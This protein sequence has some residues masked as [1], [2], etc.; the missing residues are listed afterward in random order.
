MS[1]TWLPGRFPSCA[2]NTLLTCS[3]LVFAG[4][5]SA[6]DFERYRPNPPTPPAYTPKLP[7][8][9][10]GPV[11][12]SPKILIKELKGFIVVDHKDK[13][14]ETPAE[15]HGI[16]ID[17]SSDLTL[18]RG[19]GVQSILSGYLGQEISIRK[20]NQM[21]RDIVLYY[22]K[23]GQPVVDVS[24]PPQDATDGVV[25]IVITEARIG[26]VIVK[27]GCYFDPKILAEQS[28]LR[29]GSRI[30]ERCL[31]EELIWYNQNPFR[32]VDLDLREGQH[33]GT[34]DVI[35]SLK[36]QLPL[37]VYA[38]YEDTGTR[39]T[40]RERLNYGFNCGNGLRRG[41]LMSYQ[42]TTND[43]YDNWD[44]ER[45]AVHSAS[46]SI[47]LE[48]RDELL[49]YGSFAEIEFPGRRFGLPSDFVSQGLS[50]QASVRYTR[51]QG[52]S[53]Y[54][55]D[56]RCS[57]GLDV[58]STNNLLDFGI[59]TATDNTYEVFQFMAGWVGRRQR[60]R[61]NSALGLDGFFSPGYIT[62]KN[63]DAEF[64]QFRAGADATYGY[65]RMFTEHLYDWN[66]SA[67]LV[68][69][70]AGQLAS[71]KLVATEQLGF[72]G[73]NTI[74]GYDQRALN[75]D[76]GFIGSFEVRTK[77]QYGC[78]NGKQTQ[79]TLLAFL[80][81]G[82]MANWGSDPNLDD[83]E[84]LASAGVGMRYIINPTL[85]L[86]ADYGL[87][88]NNLDQIPQASLSDYGR[89]HLGLVLAH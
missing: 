54:W 9:E 80:D 58:K 65:A 73:Y 84:V 49:F 20:L 11:T 13:I 10:Q 8:P 45:L 39:F 66:R 22:G 15:T 52:K 48:S 50:W 32:T 83:S 47:P 59:V 16:L 64:E 30:Y 89:V 29:R 85:T 88:F 68:F 33:P 19:R 31:Q 28:W 72:G 70:S 74:R 76:N 57:I 4:H 79:L 21:S 24:I 53:C 36:D 81:A 7:Q 55:D 69:R 35:F 56:N 44:A 27:G 34:T 3:F 17:P 1:T 46:Y 6:Q 87:P 38:G 77:P 67:D 18:A 14:K 78:C 62:D 41:H 2:L 61:W 25:Q 71:G 12:G 37:R 82:I 42:F 60:G 51:N 26:K 63:T 75:G 86:R 43:D 5:L 23:C 40:G